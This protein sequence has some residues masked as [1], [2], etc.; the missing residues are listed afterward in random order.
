MQ[1]ACRETKLPLVCGKIKHCRKQQWCIG[2]APLFLPTFLVKRLTA[3][4]RREGREMGKP[5]P[6]PWGCT[7]F[8]WAGTRE[9]HLE[10]LCGLWGAGRGADPLR[11]ASKVKQNFLWRTTMQEVL[12]TLLKQPYLF[13]YSPLSPVISHTIVLVVKNLDLLRLLRFML[14][15][16][17]WGMLK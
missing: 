14:T 15:V 8:H 11:D 7:N 10:E 16:S 4:S 13:G 6:T 9:T 3:K 5:V 2:L 17:R 1:R 12:Q